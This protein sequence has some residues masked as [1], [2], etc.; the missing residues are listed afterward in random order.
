VKRIIAVGIGAAAAAFAGV[1]LW[2]ASRP[3]AVAIDAGT[4]MILL[5]LVAGLSLVA[6]GLAAWLRDRH[7]RVAV[8]SVVAGLAWFLVS[9][10]NPASG[11]S[12]AFAVGLV[13]G[14]AAPPFV[15]HAVLGYPTGGI[16]GRS[17]R[18]ILVMAY[19]TNLLL[20]GLLP[21]LVYVPA[22]ESC[23]LCP[24]NPLAVGSWPELGMATR[25]VGFALAV[26]WPIAAVAL[27]VRRVLQV[28]AALRRVILPVVVP[29]GAY[30]ALA[31]LSAV[32]G[33]ANGTPGIGDPERALRAGE[34]ACLIA[35]SFGVALRWVRAA[36]TQTRIANLVVELG[37]SP[38]PGGLRDLLAGLLDDPE[39][40]IAYPA[41]AGGYVDAGGRPISLS[42]STSRRVSPLA[43]DGEVVALLE[44]RSGLEDDPAQVDEL[45]RAAG[46]AL[47]NE[48]LVARSR[49]Q[50]EAIRVSR[51]RIVAAG[52]AERRRLEADLH[53]GAQQRVV[54][55]LMAIGRLRHRAASVL[56]ASEVADIARAEAEL[57][58]A[59]DDI[60]TIGHGL[61]PALLVDEGLAS[62]VD[63]LSEE[64]S[65]ALTI[66]SMPAER[67]EPTI[68]AAAYLLISEAP[69]IAGARRARIIARHLDH[70][71]AIEVRHDGD[72]NA[73]L[74]E[75]DDRIGALDGRLTVD[76]DDGG[77]AVVRAEIPCAS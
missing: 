61:Y 5:I 71:L 27:A 66:V 3:P 52:D 8:L 6:V 13:L 47:D 34:A 12:P 11:S 17:A 23:G 24:P 74:T 46:L 28:T 39:V 9:W 40:V 56:P 14:A 57:H 15:A 63:G 50:L 22:A 7:D 32:P 62:A 33:I 49:A 29:G 48:R 1:S 70:H 73:D 64:S 59:I 60:R 20:L 68:E 16:A 26:A 18:V 77:Q 35:L 76:R 30:L 43:R 42:S 55:L 58:A 75:L 37:R 45:V 65:I 36:R 72:P 4:A 69:S 44:H 10:S 67:F 54:G 19:V 41:D 2:L 25:Q 21:T 53:D 51:A 38:P 31:G